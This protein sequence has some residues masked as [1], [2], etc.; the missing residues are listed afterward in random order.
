MTSPYCYVVVRGDIPIA[1]Q[2]VQVGHACHQA[3]AAFGAPEDCHMVV[4]QVD[5]L[6]QLMKVCRRVTKAGIRYKLFCEPHENMGNTALATE[7]IVDREIF[8]GFFLWEHNCA[9][10]GAPQIK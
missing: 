7:P 6:K 10:K 8:R 5:D 4:L 1:D 9:L 3:G 2:M